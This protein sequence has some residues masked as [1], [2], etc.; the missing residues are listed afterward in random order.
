MSSVLM[1]MRWRIALDPRL[2]GLGG[3]LEQVRAVGL[4]RRL[5]H[6]DDRGVEAARGVRHGSTGGTSMSP[7]LTS[8]S[9]SRQTV[10]DM[11]AKASS[12]SPSQVTIDFTRAGAARGQDHDGVAAADDAGGDLAGEAAEIEVGADHVLHR[13][14]QVARDCG[15]CARGTVSRCSSSAGPSYQGVRA[16][17]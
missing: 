6:P 13:E 10:T 11:G 4:Q 12:R 9:S 14:A 15:R 1:S 5:V 16:L 2:H 3:V 7:R 8:I 17:R